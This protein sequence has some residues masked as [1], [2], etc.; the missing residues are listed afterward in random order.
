MDGGQREGRRIV[1]RTPA[2]I[3]LFLAVRGVRDDS[4]HD[5]VTVMQT[6]SLHDRLSASIDCPP[7]REQHPAARR[8]MRLELHLDGTPGV[9]DHEDNLVTKA[10]LL[11]GQRVGMVD[12]EQYRER[13]TGTSSPRTSLHLDKQI[14]VAAG[15]AGG[16][17]DA[18]AALVGLN[19]L[20]KCGLGVEELKALAAKLGSDVP[21]CVVGGTALATG[22][23][24]QVARVLCRGT[25]HWV[26]GISQRPL[27][28]ASVYQ[29]WD[30]GCCPSQVEPDAVLAALSTG[31]AEALGGALCNDL[32]APALTLRPELAAKRELL[33]DAGALGAVVSGSGPTVLGLARDADDA[34]RLAGIVAPHF[35][36]VQIATSPAGGPEMTR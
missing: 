31:D 26:I 11:L 2:K 35:E 1:V 24:T 6:V 10:A 33:L 23:G 29:A 28:T 30:R 16:S 34:D 21:F 22:R 17:S 5:L 3:N 9:P 4:F 15:M 27:G 25:F 32:Q 19:R 7:G 8:R 36:R 20:W 18:A 13:A 12:P 14:P